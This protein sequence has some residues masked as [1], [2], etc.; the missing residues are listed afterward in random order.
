M[1]PGQHALPRA[2]GARAMALQLPHKPRAPMPHPSTPDARE[3]ATRPDPVGERTDPAMEAL[4]PVVEAPDQPQERWPTSIDRWLTRRRQL[5]E[6]RSK[7]E[8]LPS[9]GL[10]TGRPCLSRRPPRLDP[11]A[12][13]ASTSGTG[14]PRLRHRAGG[15]LDRRACPSRR[16]ERGGRGRRRGCGRERELGL[17][18]LYI[19]HGETAA[20]S[21][22]RSN[23]RHSF[24]RRGHRE[25]A[26]R[27]N[28]LLSLN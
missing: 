14:G 15:G 25:A 18:S 2:A 19:C 16:R 27:P 20:P 26:S 8:R 22:A 7:G 11:P 5:K 4:D 28:V 10:L 9:P 6:R 17:K 24:R 1:P 23:G 3:D 21:I 12:S 13:T